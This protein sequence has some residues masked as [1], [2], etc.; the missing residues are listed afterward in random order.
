M[1]KC[2]HIN[3]G[4]ALLSIMEI[5]IL[6]KECTNCPMFNFCYEYFK[7]DPVQLDIDSVPQLDVKI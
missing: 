4:V 1:E 6:N 3:I 7:V 5:C 2:G